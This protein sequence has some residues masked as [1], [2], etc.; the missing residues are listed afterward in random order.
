V[1]LPT[2]GILYF[3]LAHADVSRHWPMLRWLPK[4]IP[5][6]LENCPS[7]SKIT[8]SPGNQH[9]KNAKPKPILNPAAKPAVSSA[10]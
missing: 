8:S 3:R 2:A 4:V 1:V 7:L 9:Y 10:L 6:C 5:E